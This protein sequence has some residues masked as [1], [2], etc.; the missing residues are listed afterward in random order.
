[1]KISKILIRLSVLAGLLM[2]F[3]SYKGIFGPNNYTNETLNWA[4]QAMGQDIINLFLVFP[5]LLIS[6]YYLSLKSFRAFLIWIGL[7]IYMLY[8]YIL[9]AFF[10]HFSPYF[11]IY[12]AILG[13][14]FYTLLFSLINTDYKEIENYFNYIKNKIVSLFFFVVVIIFSVLWLSDI[15]KAYFSNTLPKSIIDTGLFINPVQVLDLAI[16]LPATVIIAYLLFRKKLSGYFFSL[17]MIT[18]FTAMGIAIISMVIVS[19]LIVASGNS[20]TLTLKMIISKNLY[21]LIMMSLLIIINIYLGINLF[22]QI[23]K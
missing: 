14:S 19:S 3:V 17:P 10:I 16:L 4:G 7:L 8:S 22:R 5:A 9:Y 2:A 23:K 18:F 21:Q 12:V 15:F 20:E 13:I 1:M 6:A 11:L